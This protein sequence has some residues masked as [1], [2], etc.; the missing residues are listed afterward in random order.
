[1]PYL[2]AYSFNFEITPRAASNV[3]LARFLKAEPS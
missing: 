3:A 1:M 2:V